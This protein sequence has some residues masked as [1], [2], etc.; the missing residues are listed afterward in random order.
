MVDKFI[1]NHITSE[2]AAKLL[3]IGTLAVQRWVRQGRLEAV[4][5]P[6]ID[7]RHEYLFNKESLLQW[8]NGRLSSGEAV[9]ILG[10]SAATLHR[11]IGEGK[12]G[13]LHDMGGK[14]RW[15]SREAVLRLNQEMEKK[16]AILSNAWS[17]C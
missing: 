7:E 11:W 4:S 12:I 1:A 16:R 13:P 6:R 5:G 17:G 9:D 10:V 8:R 15:F 3:G 2:E 14:Q